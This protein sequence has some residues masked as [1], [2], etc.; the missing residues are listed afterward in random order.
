M[1]TKTK[2]AQHLDIKVRDSL[3]IE[4]QLEK[5]SAFDIDDTTQTQSAD[6]SLDRKTYKII[7]SV[8]VFLTQQN[9]D[10]SDDVVQA[11]KNSSS[12]LSISTEK[13]TPPKY[14]PVYLMS[15]SNP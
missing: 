6:E 12:G 13:L 2:L 3:E 10:L 15:S 11:A 5:Y 1:I 7:L 9:L 4:R 14:R 8:D